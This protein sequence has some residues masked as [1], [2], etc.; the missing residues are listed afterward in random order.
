MVLNFSSF[1]HLQDQG[2]SKPNPTTLKVSKGMESMRRAYS[3]P[4]AFE[5]VM[6]LSRLHY[7]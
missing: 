6:V 7:H 3:Y 4:H 1:V 5:E 2:K